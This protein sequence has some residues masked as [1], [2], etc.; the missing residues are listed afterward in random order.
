ME[1][2]AWLYHS[3]FYHEPQTGEMMEKKLRTK[4]Q[5]IE[6]QRK[7]KRNVYCNGELIDRDDEL[8]Q[9]C[10]NV[11]GVT[12]EMAADPAHEDLCTAE[13]H[14]TGHRINRFTHVHQSAEDLHK[15]Q[16]MTRLLCRKVGFCIG[17]CMGIDAINGLNAVSYEADKMNNGQTE[18]Y[19]NFQSG[20]NTSRTMTWWDVAPKRT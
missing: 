17:R 10:M 1:E 15:K 12:F 8:Q 5:Y 13:S 9:G 16:D 14:I 2:A 3:G 6:G 7:L 11:M 19:N 4:E 18:Y 20:W